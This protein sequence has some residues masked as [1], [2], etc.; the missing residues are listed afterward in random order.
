M[1]AA[2]FVLKQT[3]LWVE[4]SEPLSLIRRLLKLMAWRHHM[5]M[6]AHGFFR[7]L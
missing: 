2:C 3:K 1:Q 6:L 7:E 5:Q 4:G